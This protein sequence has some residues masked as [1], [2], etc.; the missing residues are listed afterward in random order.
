MAADLL[1]GVG[2]RGPHR[3]HDGGGDR[4]TMQDRKWARAWSSKCT[5]A[6]RS[7]ESRGPRHHFGRQLRQSGTYAVVGRLSIA[8]ALWLELAVLVIGGL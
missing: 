4:L 1:A 6:Q 2:A 7:A 3:G 5:D 8:I